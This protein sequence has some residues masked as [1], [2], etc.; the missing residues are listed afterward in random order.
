MQASCMTSSVVLPLLSHLY[1]YRQLTDLGRRTAY[2]KYNFM[3]G[4]AS[5]NAVENVI[6]CAF[7]NGGIDLCRMVASI[8]AHGW[9]TAPVHGFPSFPNALK[10]LCDCLSGITLWRCKTK[11]RGYGHVAAPRRQCGNGACI[12]SAACL[13]STCFRQSYP[14]SLPGIPAW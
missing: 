1:Q 13:R 7:P 9:G 2:L 10:L 11:R 4:L 12:L 8:D 5:S 3:T 14:V 6:V